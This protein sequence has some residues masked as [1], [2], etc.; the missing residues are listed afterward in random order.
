MN[1]SAGYAIATNP[2]A[3]AGASSDSQTQARKSILP[4]SDDAPFLDESDALYRETLLYMRIQL[5]SDQKM[6][7]TIKLMNTVI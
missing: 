5:G 1:N 3:A 4:K 7:E 6:Y 2:S